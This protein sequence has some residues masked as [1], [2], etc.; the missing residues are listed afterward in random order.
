MKILHIPHAY[1]PVLGGAE[2]HCAE[3]SRT[4]AARGHQVTVITSNA[5]SHRSYDA[6]PDAVNARSC[7]TLRGVKVRRVPIFSTRQ[8][9]VYRLLFTALPTRLASRLWQ[10]QR[11]NHSKCLK[12]AFEHEIVSNRPDVVMTMPHHLPNVQYVVELAKRLPFPLAMLP[13]LHPGWSPQTKA[14]LKQAFRRSDAVIANTQAE[15]DELVSEYEVPSE[16][17]FIGWLGVASSQ[18]LVTSTRLPQVLYLGRIVESKNLPLLLNAMQIVWQTSPDA[19]LVLA[20]ASDG[21]SQTLVRRLMESAGTQVSKITLRFNISDEEKQGLLTES[22][23]LV[24]PSANE[25]FGI[26]L[27]EAMSVA[28]PVVALKLP[29]FESF[30]THGTNA[31]LVEPDSPSEMA[32]AISTLLSDHQ[33]SRRLGTAGQN[34]ARERFT[35]E[36]VAQRYEEAYLYACHA[37]KQ[38]AFHF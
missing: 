29:V 13:L 24:L 8:A 33:Q 7:E 11:T 35:W 5:S 14:W 34:M 37:R 12:A 1:A 17:T 21:G 16:K 15:A 9:W 25:S 23:C 19:K 32:K 36:A 28:T 22:Q 6:V 3:L 18:T 27:L 31:L 20:G 2:K 38:M 10:V 30:L 4:L 26:V